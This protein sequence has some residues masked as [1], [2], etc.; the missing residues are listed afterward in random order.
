MT[1]SLPEFNLKKQISW[2]FHIDDRSKSPRIYDMIIDQGIDLLGELGMIMD[3]N[4]D[5]FGILTLFQ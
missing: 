4:D 1:S 2:I 3:F 5:H